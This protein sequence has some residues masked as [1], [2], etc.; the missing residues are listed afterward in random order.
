MFEVEI[1]KVN[2]YGYSSREDL[3][4]YANAEKKLCYLLMLK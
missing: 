1:S 2:I 4:Q 3:I